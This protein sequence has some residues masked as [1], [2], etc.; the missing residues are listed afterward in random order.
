MLVF[1]ADEVATLVRAR[2]ILSAHGVTTGV[3]VM[4]TVLGL[5]VVEGAE[6]DGAVGNSL[7]P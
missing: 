7:L 2:D 5:S 4:T 3:M 1:K 6:D